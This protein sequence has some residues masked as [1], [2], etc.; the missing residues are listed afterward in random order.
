MVLLRSR[1]CGYSNTMTG[2]RV[3]DGD[4]LIFVC[5]IP[6]DTLG[7]YVEWSAKQ[8]VVCGGMDDVDLE[9]EGDFT[10]LKGDVVREATG[11]VDVAVCR[12]H[13]QNN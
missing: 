1:E 10:D 8:H 9:V 11:L 2:V 12:L 6:D 3:A 13:V 7:K 4:S 5:E